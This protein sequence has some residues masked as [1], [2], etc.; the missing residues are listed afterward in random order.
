MDDNNFR[1]EFQFLA[2]LYVFVR[3]IILA[4]SSLPCTFAIIECESPSTQDSRNG[5]LVNMKKNQAIGF[6]AKF[7]LEF[8]CEGTAPTIV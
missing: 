6:I 2:E 7:E 1:N 8:V 5:Q 4:R 3:R